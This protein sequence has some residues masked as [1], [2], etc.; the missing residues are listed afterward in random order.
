M[1]AGPGSATVVSAGN[2]GVIVEAG[3]R[4]ILVDAF[5]HHLPHV[6]T[7]PFFR[8]RAAGRADLLL[9]THDHPDHFDPQAVLEALDATGAAFVGPAGAVRRLAAA[10]RGLELVELEPE[11]GRTPP[12][13]RSAAPRGIRVTA[14]RTYHGQAHNSY[15]VE[16]GTFRFFHDGD[17]ER[18]QH[19]QASALGRLD[20]VFL[21]PWQGSGAA[22]FLARTRPGRVFLVHL[23]DG[24]LD[25]HDAGELLPGLMDPVPPDLVALRP[26]GRMEV[27]HG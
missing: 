22:G 20:A 24:E 25:Q 4:R 26:G 10:A 13:S 21:C 23:T 3:G 9:V 11:D 17:N 16:A 14:F 18:T 6:G 19:L 8:P 2:A 27:A 12:A 15:L 1:S 7:A 5:F